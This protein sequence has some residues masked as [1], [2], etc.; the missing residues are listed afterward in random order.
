MASKELQDKNP[1][2]IIVPQVEES[3]RSTN[4]VVSSSE[5]NT[6]IWE[7]LDSVLKEYKGYINESRIYGRWYASFEYG[8]TKR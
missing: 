2:I 7:L 1:A 3:R 5:A 6:A 4:D 8:G